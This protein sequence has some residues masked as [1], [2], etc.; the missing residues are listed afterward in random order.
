MSQSDN[1]PGRRSALEDEMAI[2]A[3][4][5]AYTDAINRFD[6]D[7]IARVYDEDSVLTMMD[8]PSIVGRPAI[9][10]MLRATVAR[11]QL[12]MQLVHSGIV[13]LDGDTAQAR[14]QITELQVTLEGEP[15]FVAGR[16]EDELVRRA[17]G[18]QFTRRT[19]TARYLGD[20][21]MTSGVLPDPPVR[22]P[23]FPTQPGNAAD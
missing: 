18:W 16:Y 8:R 13:H 17:H 4:V 19:F 15:R 7:D 6:I 9:L 20:I 14:W 2:R 10:D 11:Y 22:F 21:A 12:V 3:L 23:Q 5:A 1:D